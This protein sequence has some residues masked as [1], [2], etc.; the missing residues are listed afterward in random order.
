M[1]D[2][3]IVIIDF[4]DSFTYNIGEIIYRYT[5]DFSIISHQ[6][7]FKFKSI[8]E[9]NN[10]KV[11]ILGPG[12]GHPFDYKKYYPQIKSLL[13]SKQFF[14][15]GICLGH[16]IIASILGFEIDYAISPFHGESFEINFKGKK[17]LVQR[18]NSLAVKN[19]LIK[20]VQSLVL[21]QEV[22]LLEAS[23]FIS[24]QFHPE[25]IGTADQD[26][27]FMKFIENITD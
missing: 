20:N 18:Y 16:Q 7:F 6:E 10:I 17:I 5:K 22:Q 3:K 14:L 1:L 15:M 24:Y 2:K 8:D 12:P 25:S 27:F 26:L 19:R 11:I 21:N 9:L 23:N 13:D 4:E